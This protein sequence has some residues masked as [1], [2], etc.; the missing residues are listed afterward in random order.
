MMFRY[1]NHCAVWQIGLSS[2]ERWHRDAKMLTI[3]EEVQRGP[4]PP[5]TCI[6][7]H[8]PEP[9]LVAAAVRRLTNGLSDFGPRSRDTCTC[10]HLP[11]LSNHW[12]QLSGP[13]R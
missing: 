8:R 10:G 9:P 4:G 11:C 6:G 5:F 7:G 13:V 3:F 12:C 1:G 2:I